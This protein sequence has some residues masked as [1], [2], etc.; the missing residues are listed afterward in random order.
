MKR[1]LRTTGLIFAVFS[2]QVWAGSSEVRY[3]KPP[4]WVVATPVPTSA[5]TPPGAPVR[6]DYL[7]YQIHAGPDGDQI[8]NASRMRILKPEALSAG[9]VILS[10]SPDTGDATVHHL[11]IVRE[12]R[13]IDVLET[14]K[15][16]VLRREGYL[17]NAMLNGNLTAVLQVPGLRVGD[18]LEFAATVT[19]RDQTLGDHSF[20]FVQLPALGM[21]GAYRVRLVW[22]ESGELVWRASTD[23]SGLAEKVTKGQKELIYEL[24]D[25]G[26]PIM[27][28]G[29]PSR[30]NIRR[31]IEYTDFKAW[32]SISR[33]IWPLFDAASRIE[34]NSPVRKEIERIAQ[35]FKDPTQRVE[36]ALQLV[37]EDIR[38]V[39]V[40]LGGGNLRPATIE[41]TWERRF[42]DCKAKSVLLVGILRELGISAESVLVRS[43]G[44][45]GLNERLP[46]PAQF[47]HVLVKTT[48]AGNVY[49]LDGTRLGDKSLAALSVPPY[50][51]YLPLRELGSALEFNRL[52]VPRAPQIIN[53]MELDAFEGFDKRAKVKGQIILRGP[54]AY[55]IRTSLQ[56]MNAE[57][58]EREIK[59]YW[60]KDND[61][62]EAEAGAWKYDE[63]RA[64]LRLSVKLE[65]KGDDKEGHR[66]TL[67]GAGF[68]PPNE[69]RRPREQDQNAPWTANYGSFRC[70]ATAI[71]LPPATGKWKWDYRSKP[72]QRK[73]GATT[74][75]RVA[76]MRGGIVRTVMSTRVDV[77]EISATEALEVNRQIPDFDNA[78]SDVIQIG[79]DEALDDHPA[80]PN[81]VFNDSTDWMAEKTQCSAPEVTGN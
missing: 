14:T 33:A 32:P 2:C 43:A 42:G 39:Y 73:L 65:W 55:S 7:D 58:A 29:A 50:Q 9:N 35:Q 25:P 81:F 71:R 63:E 6:I 12:G 46:S 61:W 8:F 5:P 13:P 40:G 41:Q 68:Y 18:S 20:G 26:A 34:P 16:Q 28:N 64:V 76:H 69:Y 53:V 36:A 52:P 49:W 47:D 22:P 80:F 30:F 38:Y 70:N 4:A 21:P 10:W 75:W 66:F 72:V 78:M 27:T 51:W 15:F 17:E 44:G 67:F 54:E 31:A 77:P 48:V 1:V 74:Y 19:R 37:Q 59:A 56:S 24:R 57:D 23:I 79:K 3:D 60:E 62:L 45:D 11:R